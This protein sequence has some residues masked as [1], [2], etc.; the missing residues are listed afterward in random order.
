MGWFLKKLKKLR[1]FSNSLCNPHFCNSRFEVPSL[2]SVAITPFALI[3]RIVLVLLP[4]FYLKCLP[5][6]V[7]FGLLKSTREHSNWLIPH[8]PV[9]HSSPYFT[10]FFAFTF[11]FVLLS[12]RLLQHNTSLY[13]HFNVSFNTFKQTISHKHLAQVTFP[14]TTL[15]SS[16]Q[17]AL[18]HYIGH[19]PLLL[20][21][22]SATYHYI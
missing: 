19:K 13:F 15:H 8:H 2:S 5:C 10:T 17:L 20:S 18:T 22:Y 16:Y 6:S 9:L 12:T 1:F 14:H 11:Q 21:L 4:V 7:L 3:K